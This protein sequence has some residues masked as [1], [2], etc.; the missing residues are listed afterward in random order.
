MRDDIGSLPLSRDAKRYARLRSLRGKQSLHTR[1]IYQLLNAPSGRSF[2][3][4]NHDEGV[5]A[6]FDGRSK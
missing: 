2:E 1:V 4:K 5:V 3:F 6:N